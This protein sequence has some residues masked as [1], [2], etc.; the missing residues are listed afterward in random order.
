MGQG[1]GERT[2]SVSVAAIFA[3]VRFVATYDG[4]IV[5]GLAATAALGWAAL[6]VRARPGDPVAPPGTRSR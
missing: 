5:L 3:I 1:T 6:A 4:A 2:T